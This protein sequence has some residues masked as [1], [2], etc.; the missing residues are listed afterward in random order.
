MWKSIFP[1]LKNQAV[2]HNV[3]NSGGKGEG[4]RYLAEGFSNKVFVYVTY[5]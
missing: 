3:E 5:F 1:H 4:I 2:I